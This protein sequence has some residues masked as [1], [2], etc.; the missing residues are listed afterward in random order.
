[1][2][3][4]AQPTLYNPSSGDSP[5]ISGLKSVGR[6]LGWNDPNAV[7]GVGV[8]TPASEAA[9]ALSALKM[10]SPEATQLAT[11]SASDVINPAT[12]S[13][14]ERMYQQASPTFKGMQ[15]AGAF[16][17]NR[18]VGSLYQPPSL[19]LTNPE[20]TAIGDES[21]FNLNRPPTSPAVS[22][23]DA[24]YQRILSQKGR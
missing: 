11:Q 14:M 17:G 12:A 2:P 13:Q 10:M 7:M 6:M 24:A 1:M 23:Q 19:G 15:N 3:V 18:S 20:F 8:P 9:P 22:P 4:I 5:L 16:S 21:G